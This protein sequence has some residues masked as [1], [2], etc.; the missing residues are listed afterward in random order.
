M[1]QVWGKYGASMGQVYGSIYDFYLR[2]PIKGID[3]YHGMPPHTSPEQPLA[4]DYDPNC[5][6]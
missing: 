4:N 1:G 3:S 2:I 5:M 6:Q